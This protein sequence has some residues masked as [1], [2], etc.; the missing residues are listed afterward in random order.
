MML[1]FPRKDGRGSRI[2][3]PWQSKDDPRSDIDVV[4]NHD[5]CQ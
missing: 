5:S 3:L 1:E 2:S 4:K